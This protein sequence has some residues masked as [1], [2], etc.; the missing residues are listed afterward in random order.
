MSS[1]FRTLRASLSVGDIQSTQYAAN[2]ELKLKVTAQFKSLQ[3]TET[4]C[5]A[6]AEQLQSSCRTAAEQLRPRCL[7]PAYDFLCRTNVEEQQ[8]FIIENQKP[9]ENTCPPFFPI[10]RVKL[11]TVRLAYCQI[12][13][14]MIRKT[15]TMNPGKIKKRKPH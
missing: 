11:R 13:R 7:R 1:L 12:L 5:K 9:F 14:Q 15:R 2:V 10:T 3:N 6:A 8:E 4:S